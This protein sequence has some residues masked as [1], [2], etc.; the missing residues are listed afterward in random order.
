[1]VTEFTIHHKL[2]HCIHISRD[3]YQMAVFLRMCRLSF[4]NIKQVYLITTRSLS[5]KAEKLEFF[6]VVTELLI[7]TP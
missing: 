1:M 2:K 6:L 5:F 3:F 7:Q 4:F